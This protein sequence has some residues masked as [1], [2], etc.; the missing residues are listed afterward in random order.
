MKEVKIEHFNEKD[1]RD[2]LRLLSE[3]KLPTADLTP[4]KLKHFLVAR[5]KDGAVIGVVGFERYGKAGLLRSLVVDPFY[6]GEG[7][8]K[9]LVSGL[10]ASS[11]K[12]GVKTQFLLTTTAADFF[13]KLGYS[14]TQRSAVPEA[15][16]NTEE[17]KSICPVSAVCLSKPLASD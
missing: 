17:F 4:E 3:A 9:E 16:A 14:A 2:V 5:Q 10:E 11:R 13:Q 7:L 6:R 15:I 12:L 8:G 1:R